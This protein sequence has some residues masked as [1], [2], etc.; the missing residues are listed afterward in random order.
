MTRDEQILHDI[1]AAS[2]PSPIYGRGPVT[3]IR[4]PK[5]SD[6]WVMFIIVTIVLAL[7]AL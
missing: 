5:I 1:A 3:S 2:K 6:G 7:L 4:K